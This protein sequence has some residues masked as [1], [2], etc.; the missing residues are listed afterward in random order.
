VRIL[1]LGGTWFLG[2]AVVEE[3][4]RRGHEVTTFNR[5]RTA[6]DVLGAEVVRGDR[7]APA[8]LARLVAG[9]TWDAV[10][11]T[12]GYVP[13]NVGMTARTLADHA[14]R[15]V[16]CSTLDAYDDWP[17]A[18]VSESSPLHECPLDAGPDDAPYGHLKAGCERALRE[19]YGAERSLSLRLGI[20]LGPRE[21]RGRLPWWLRRI[22][23]GGRVLAPA[24]QDRRI[25]VIDVRDVA[26]FTLG[27][28]DDWE[29]G[30]VNVSARSGHAT[31]ASW[32]ADCR[33]VTG[34]DA[35]FVWAD[36]DV[37][38]REGV[39]DWTELP[40]WRTAPGTW[41]MD[42]ERA[43]ARGLVCRPLADTVTDTWAWLTSGGTVPGDG[44]TADHGIGPDRELAL[45]NL[46]EVVA[47][48]DRQQ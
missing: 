42:V 4:L 31:F 23:R 6:A 35:E 43:H 11:D 21:P 17:Q 3:A 28:L 1:V 32:L 16:F 34:S 15:Y 44:L 14:D 9:R 36:P 48:P 46:A 22:A 33:S 39:R 37:L 5:G 10:I 18:P 26:A 27:S 7:E 13:R 40:L 20:M 2:R 30:A 41:L 45:L 12:S 24:P 19:V 8:D 38:T 47:A 29:G 25:Q